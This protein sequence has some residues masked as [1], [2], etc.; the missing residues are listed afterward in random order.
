MFRAL[1]SLWFMAHRKHISH[2]A[3]EEF[4]FSLEEF[5]C[6]FIFYFPT[7]SRWTWTLHTSTTGC[8]TFKTQDVSLKYS[9]HIFYVFHIYGNAGMKDLSWWAFWIWTY[10]ANEPE[11]SGCSSLR[12]S[13]SRARSH[14]FVSGFSSIT[15]SSNSHGGFNERSLEWLSIQTR[16]PPRALQETLWSG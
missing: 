5:S 16:A 8:Q 6:F 13:Y 12:R 11:D 14:T 15:I 4:Q 2:G 10:L 9:G 1:F 7:L 3:G